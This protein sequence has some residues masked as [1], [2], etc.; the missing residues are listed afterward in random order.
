MSRNSVTI[1]LPCLN[2]DKTLLKC[3]TKIKKVMNKSSYAKKYSILVCDNGSTDKSIEICK[4]HKIDYIIEENKGY[5]NALIA[6]IKKAKTKYVVMLDSDLSYNE[7]D[8]PRFISELENGSDLVVGNRFKGGIKEKAMPLS[9]KIGSSFLTKYANSLFYTRIHDFHCGIRAFDQKK[10]IDTGIKSPGFE[11]AS[12]MIIRAKI[13][14]LKISEIDTVLSKDGRN[15]KSHLRTIRDGIRHLREIN[16]LKF[17]HSKIFR[18]ATTFLLSIAAISIFTIGS[19][20]IPHNLVKG[21]VVTS[22]EEFVDIVKENEKDGIKPYRRFEKYG[23][24]KNYAMIFS[25]NEKDPIRSAVEMN[26]LSKC[27]NIIRC[28]ESLLL[29]DGGLTSYNR[30]WQGQSSAIHYVTP[31]MSLKIAITFFTILFVILLV[32]VLYKLF[33]ADKS[34]SIALFLGLLSI[35]ISFVTRSLEFLPVMFVMLTTIL[36]VLKSIKN[37]GKNLDIIFLVSG[38][39]TCFFDFLTCETITLT[40]P[41]IAYVFLEIKNGRKV[42]FKRIISL[43]A[44]WGFGYALTFITKWIISFFYLGPEE[45]HHTFAHMTTNVINGPFLKNVIAPIALT[46]SNLLPFAFLNSGALLLTFSIAMCFIY[47]ASEDKEKLK[48]YFICLVPI[49]RFYVINGHSINLHYFTYRALICVIV[50]L[51]LTITQMLKRTFEKSKS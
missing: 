28:K 36:F 51:V 38:I 3:V 13:K 6:G 46:F 9:H 8:I 47:T 21:N 41:L 39:M 17:E 32:I 1:I 49:L 35:N 25:T 30:Y 27:K 19:C 12:E 34:L 11:F 2:E 16:K 18:Y 37:G 4:K 26:Y 31:F 48:L 15:K 23:D 7:K 42:S 45:F 24:V 29:Y 43:M 22:I 20:L 10:M 44:L 40:V 50:V 14:K 33:K 5:G